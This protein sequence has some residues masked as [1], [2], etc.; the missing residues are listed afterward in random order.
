M[1]YPLEECHDV[2]VSLLKKKLNNQKKPATAP[3]E[4]Q[5]GGEEAKTADAKKSL[6]NASHIIDLRRIARYKLCGTS[7]HEFIFRKKDSEGVC[8]AS[9]LAGAAKLQSPL[10]GKEKDNS[11]DSDT[12]EDTCI[13]EEF[14][15]NEEHIE[16]DIKRRVA[17][18]AGKLALSPMYEYQ[19]RQAASGMPQDRPRS[20]SMMTPSM[21]ALMNRRPKQERYF[22][23]NPLETKGWQTTLGA[24]AQPKCE[25]DLVENAEVGMESGVKEGIVGQIRNLRVNNGV[26]DAIKSMETSLARSATMYSSNRTAGRTESAVGSFIAV[27]PLPPEVVNNVQ[28]PCYK[29]EEPDLGERRRSVMLTGTAANALAGLF[30]RPKRLPLINDIDEANDAEAEISPSFGKRK[31]E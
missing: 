24:G 26:G 19:L 11:S 22:R 30:G 3:L 16:T 14:C 23:M 6:I 12:G 10:H 21:P 27:P 13:A 4:E 29:Y 25:G 1:V 20:I 9:K 7:A 2:Y 28:N 15:N 31:P 18:K 5:G 8:A 17:I